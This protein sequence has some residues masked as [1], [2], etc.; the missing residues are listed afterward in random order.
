MLMLRRG[1]HIIS[2]QLAYL[3]IIV[4][5]LLLLGAV[6]L[7]LLSN[8]VEQRQDEIADW[9]GNKLGYPVT[10]GSANIQRLGILPKLHIE[11]FNVYSK[12]QTVQ[13]VS[14][15]SLHLGLD[16]LASFQHGEP[17]LNDIRLSGLD[18]TVIKDASGE[19]SLKDFQLP[20]IT[21]TS[22]NDWLGY[23]NILNS[24]HLQAIT[25]DY[26]DVIHPALSGKYQLANS[27]V[28]HDNLQW[29]TRGTLRL[30][31]GI[32]Q[33]LQ[34]NLK[35][36]LHQEQLN[37]ATWK[38][39]LNAQNLLVSSFVDF[40]AWEDIAI[41]NGRANVAIS[42][43]GVGTQLE[44]V[45]TS[46][47]LNQLALVS[48]SSENAE[49]VLVDELSGDFEWQAKHESWLLVGRDLVLKMNEEIWEKTNF[50]IGK[51]GDLWSAE[52]NYLRLSDFTSIALLTALSPEILRQY[53]PAG[54]IR[55]LS[56]RYSSEGIKKLKFNVIEAGVLAWKEYP[57]VSNLTARV[58]WDDQTINITMN[59]KESYLYAKKWLDKEVK[60]DSVQGNLIFQQ[61]GQAWS[62]QTHGLRFWN[63]DLDLQL[64]GDLERTALGKMQSNLTFNISNMLV[65]QWQNY[66]PQ[67][68][69]EKGF[70]EWANP[71]FLN[72]NIAKGK[73][74]LVGDLADFPYDQPDVKGRFSMALE[75]EEVQLHYAPDWPDIV[76]VSGTIKGLGNKLVI[77]S[78]TGT[79]AGFQFDDVTTTITRLMIDK[80]ELRVKGLLKGTTEQAL[81]FLKNSPLKERFSQ[82]V[83][84]VMA[85]GES[86]INLN[87]MV[88]LAD[89][90]STQ[91]SGDVS[92][93][94]SELYD[95]SL[96]EIKL[97]KIEGLL[98][99][100]GEKGID[101]TKN[102]RATLLNNTV[103]V[104]VKPSD[105]G[106]IVSMEG[107]VSSQDVAAIWPQ[108]MPGFIDGETEYRLNLNVKEKALGD[109]YVDYDLT[110]ELL[111][112]EISLPEPFNKTSQEKLDFKSTLQTINDEK[113][114]TVTY[115]KALNL[116]AINNN[117]NWRMGVLFGTGVA[118]K[119]SNGVMIRGSLAELSLDKWLQWSKEQPNFTNN[120]FLSKID[121]VSMEITTLTGFDHELSDVSYSINKDAQGWQIN[122]NSEQTGLGNIYLPNDFKGPASL[123]IKL[124]KLS[125]T[126]AEKEDE[127][128]ETRALWPAMNIAIQALTI[129]DLD[130]G[131]VQVNASRTEQ[132][133]LL[134]SAS[135]D[136]KE[137]K[138]SL[139]GSS[140]NKIPNGDY[141]QLKLKLTSDNL[142]G[143]LAQLGYQQSIEADKTS[144]NA[145]INWPANPFELSRE[146]L[147]G[148]FDLEVGK[149]KLNDVEPGAAGRI[150]GLISIT[151]LP[152]LLSLNFND[153]FSKG[154]VFDS[155]SSSFNL[156]NGIAT[157]DDFILKGPSA[158]IEISG[159]VDLVK[160]L[161][162][163][164]VK[165]TPNVSSTLPVAG[166]VA[167][168]PIGLGVGTA[169]L[170]ADKLVGSLFGKNIVNLISYKYNLAG[171]WDSPEFTVA[172]PKQQ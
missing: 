71:A 88:P 26:I 7:Y 83:E 24:F 36:I 65:N 23:L 100:D 67:R 78:K 165:I 19:F 8:E 77:E 46:L 92:F 39:Q 96:P 84:S 45:E 27:I 155:I 164:E 107:T 97:T 163:Q 149:G 136:T 127:I 13:L 170:L 33:Q 141:S 44:A 104:D 29:S 93:N 42:V 59:S 145:N 148:D 169:I 31:N 111:G 16:V 171:A 157:T 58:D 2:K 161:Y 123:D 99:F 56:L 98:N 75:V 172:Q 12:D 10:I 76:G 6:S 48:L 137:F 120:S 51:E 112:V 122:L 63:K 74:E 18:I 79:I 21:S 168:G 52:S 82:A 143:A 80:P 135:I 115:G 49:P 130:L 64:D 133:W 15:N 9:V 152:R 4:T 60:F 62:L 139:S 37:I 34:F 57:G 106:S 138:A 140:W 50:S 32:G 3:V 128:I 47:S 90:Y 17:V 61:D 124:E 41:E 154:F 89:A 72:G 105:K 153:I 1:F 146:I 109:F 156:K 69:L 81:V 166:A 86:N 55:D 25:V 66:I 94:N 85:K 110:T 53:K 35:T 147:N 108:N 144:L 14:L 5:A 68:L 159:E 54:D 101:T 114:Y 28:N 20:T 134:N 129:N 158:E 22:S 91:V 162:D 70:K 160:E 150:F 151:S 102:I 125:V 113:I 38:G 126:L 40:L 87:L 142:A 73:I 131:L 118:P 95:E 121:D 117:E 11:N 116:S 30:P 43:S 167:G 132:Q 103:E 119:P